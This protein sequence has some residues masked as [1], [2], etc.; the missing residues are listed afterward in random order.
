MTTSPRRRSSMNPDAAPT[1]CPGCLAG[2]P[3][4]E[5]Q[6]GVLHLVP[7][8]LREQYDVVYRCQG[9]DDER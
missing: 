4:R 1:D 6:W 7:W 5:D 8:G 9:H 3:K 2:W